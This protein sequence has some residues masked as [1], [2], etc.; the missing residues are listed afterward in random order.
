MAIHE[1]AKVV[2]LEIRPGTNIKAAWGRVDFRS[3]APVKVVEN[4][5]GKFAILLQ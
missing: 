4:E 5:Y 2:E 1:D 3:A